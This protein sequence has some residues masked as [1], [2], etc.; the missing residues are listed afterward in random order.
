MGSNKEKS[1]IMKSIL[2]N[3]QF[4]SAIR[5]SS[6]FG[7]TNI[8]LSKYIIITP[9]LAVCTLSRKRDSTLEKH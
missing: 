1:N 9:P 6:D 4:N 2:V 7:C 8:M 5:I 3:Y